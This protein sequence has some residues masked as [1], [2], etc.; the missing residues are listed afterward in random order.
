[1][2]INEI[3]DTIID[4]FSLFDDWLDKY[5]YIIEIAKDLPEIAAEFKTKENLING[6][7]SKVWLGADLNDGIIKFSA[8]SDAIITKGIIS[9]LIK[10]YNNRSP[11]EIM[12]S[13]IY[14]I[15]KIGL[16]E[17]LSPTRAN[18]LLSMMKQIKLYAIA[19]NSKL[20]K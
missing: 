12:D 20:N 11:K 3:Q 5:N 10:V 16:E 15:K 9:L 17:N 7:Q 4:E 2:T 8:D 13:E 6:C 14:F 18:G 19:Y 1:M